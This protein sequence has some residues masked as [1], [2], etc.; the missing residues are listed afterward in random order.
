[1]LTRQH[2]SFL[3]FA[4]I[5]LLGIQCDEPNSP[6]IFNMSIS[7]TPDGAG[8]VIPSQDL[9]LPE[10]ETIQILAQPS[11][12]YAFTGWTGSISSNENPLT[13]T[14]TENIDLTANFLIK[15]Y[16]LTVSTVGS[17]TVIESIITSK[18]DYD[19]GTIV[20]LQAIAED[21]WIF[22]G[23]SGAYSSDQDIIEITVESELSITAT[24]VID[25][26][27]PVPVTKTNDMKIFVHYMPWFQS[28]PYD[29]FWGT[30]WTMSN[31]NPNNIIDGQRDIAS[32]FYPLI[33]P[34]SSKDPDVAEY[35]LLLMKYA[36]IDGIFIDWYGTYDVNDYRLNLEGSENIIDLI[37]EVGLEF[38][39]VYEDQTT[40]QVVNA[41]EA[42]TTIEAATND[43]QYI[44]YNYFSN[45]NYARVDGNPLAL[46]WTPIEIESGAAWSQ[47]L[48]DV[49]PNLMLLA[50]WYQVG[51]LGSTG[52]GEYG[53]V[54]GGNGNHLQEIINFYNNRLNRY[55][56]GIGTA[57]PGF[58]DF[59]EEG[60]QGD[61]IGWEI[62]H[63]TLE[64]TLDLATQ[65]NVDYLQLVT[66][67]DFGEG[68]IFEPTLETGYTYLKTVQTFAGVSPDSD[69][70]GHFETIYDLYQARKEYADNESI[71]E[72]LDLAFNY[73][74]VLQPTKARNI[75][76]NLNK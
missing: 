11:N 4:T 21:G 14:V 48:A 26:V 49:D 52:D 30:H 3:I 24:F 57:Y 54:Y 69:V 20:Q 62:P 13:V 47:I 65:Y 23:W 71:Q 58:F 35:H 22:S 8:T 33:G 40:A 63:S 51:D 32:H 2:Y 64:L 18:T 59:Y 41:G 19:H 68:T 76:Q 73:L 17:G 10:N 12:P 74:V 43:W 37:D 25:K 75:L 31:R 5:I 45:P 36:G 61:V 15:N 39:I 55:D 50:L 34:Y 16:P 42:S 44:Q 9:S 70:I 1:M 38:G 53:W 66:W 46:V 67:N 72:Q 56:L 29:G 6:T 7:I 60:G 28:A 27:E